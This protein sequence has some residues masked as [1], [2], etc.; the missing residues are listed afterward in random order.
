M[1]F[2]IVDDDKSIVEAVTIGLQFQ[3]QDADVYAAK[4]GEEG[5]RM[6]LDLAPDVT[7]LDVHMPY[8]SGFAVIQKIREVLTERSVGYRFARVAPAAGSDAG[9]ES[10]SR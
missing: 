1:K 8:M 7:L 5:L 6:F 2:L 10:E 4:D 3:W 9:I